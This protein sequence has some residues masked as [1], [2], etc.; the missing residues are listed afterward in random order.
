MKGCYNE[1]LTKGTQRSII[2]ELKID[3]IAKNSLD[4]ASV[5]RPINQ[6]NCFYS[7]PYTF[8]AALKQKCHLHF[9]NSN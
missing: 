9:L 1:E 4:M 7:V 8:I 3:R 5:H 6:R 2:G